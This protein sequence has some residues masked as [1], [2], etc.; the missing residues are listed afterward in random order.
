MPPI[1]LYYSPLCPFS[2]MVWLFMLECGIPVEMH[3]VDLLKKDHD[4]DVTYKKFRGYSKS[5]QVPLI[6]DGNIVLEERFVAGCYSRSS[7]PSHGALYYACWHV[8]GSHL[9]AQHGYSHLLM[10]KVLPFIF[11]VP[12]F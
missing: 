12:V 9:T 4:L 7:P 5:L 3:K 8:L 2:R 6:V 10:R 1:Q 11:L